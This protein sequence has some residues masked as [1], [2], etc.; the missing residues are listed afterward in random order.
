[1][2]FHAGLSTAEQIS[3]VSGRGV[4]LDV[5]RTKLAEHDGRIT[6]ESQVGVGTTFRL[7]IPIRKAVVVIDG[8]MVLQSGEQFVL[9]F[10]HVLEITEI[11]PGD[12]NYVQNSPMAS[13]RG[14]TYPAPCLGDL[15]DLP[16]KAESAAKVRP[17]ILVGCKQGNACLLVDEVIGH[18]QIVVNN[19][20]ETIQGVDNVA[21]VAQLGAGRL[22]LVLSVP[23]LVQRFGEG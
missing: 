19:I 2:I 18:R 9:P 20:S 21:G 10:D 12:L 6:V 16:R 4:G 15:L 13:V 17:G 7:E 11:R 22:A 23:D 1:M 8:L 3:E 5:V 14:K